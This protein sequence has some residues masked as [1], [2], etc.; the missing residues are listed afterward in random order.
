MKCF[1]SDF[2]LKFWNIDWSF[3]SNYLNYTAYFA[4]HIN[5]T[6]RNFV[7]QKLS[8]LIPDGIEIVVTITLNYYRLNSNQN[9]SY[10]SSALLFST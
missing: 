5:N 8:P 9:L 10:S 6:E 1:D 2:S 4:I 7:I 3:Q